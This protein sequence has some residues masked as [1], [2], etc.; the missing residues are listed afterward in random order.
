MVSWAFGF[1]HQRPGGPSRPGS[2]FG[3][4]GMNGSAAYADALTGGPL[5]ARLGGPSLLTPAS[6]VPQYVLNELRRVLT[7]DG[8]GIVYVVG[9]PA[10][11]S[12]HAVGQLRAAGLQV[13]RVSGQSRYDVAVGVARLVDDLRG[14]APTSAIVTSGSAF[15]DALVAGPVAVQL[16]APV[17]LSIGSTLPPETEVYLASLGASADVYAIGGSGAGSV[18]GDPRAQ[19]VGGA[20]RY[21]V[22]RNVAVRFFPQ[23]DV[24][25]LVDGRNWPDA[26]SGG[27][28]AARWRMPVALANGPAAVLDDQ[29]E[30]YRASADYVIVVGGPASVSDEQAYVAIDAAGGQSVMGQWVRFTF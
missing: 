10:S 9:G 13:Q 27:T 15:A 20:T 3:M 5:A 2:T 7:T 25:T 6:S 1:S 16:D 14:T 24:I 22:A 28:M 23:V 21:D 26:V 12:D 29:V 4:V 18:A 30:R 17:L 19:T 8:S 11:V